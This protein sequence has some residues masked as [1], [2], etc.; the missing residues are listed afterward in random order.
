[1]ANTQIAESNKGVCS[2][3]V[4][5]TEENSFLISILYNVKQQ[6]QQTKKAKRLSNFKLNGHL[7]VFLFCFFFG[8]RADQ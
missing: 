4:H 6:M 1:M 5:S 7:V 3:S 2:A 8:F